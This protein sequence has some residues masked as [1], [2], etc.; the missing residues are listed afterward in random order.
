MLLN[1][2]NPLLDSEEVRRRLNVGRRTLRELER[3]GVLPCVR[4]GHRTVRYRPE[5]VERIRIQGA[6]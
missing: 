3:R 1:P 6:M 5:D 4:L 2:I